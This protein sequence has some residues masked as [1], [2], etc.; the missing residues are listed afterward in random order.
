MK[1][2]GSNLYWRDCLS[3]RFLWL[4]F[5]HLQNGIESLLS[6][7]STAIGDT[8][9]F[10]RPWQK[11]D[12]VTLYNPYTQSIVTKHITRVGGIIYKYLVNML[13]NILILWMI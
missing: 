8:I 3:H 1:N 9:T 12:V 10:K 4:N 11:G 6:R 2:N 5:N 13:K 7:Q